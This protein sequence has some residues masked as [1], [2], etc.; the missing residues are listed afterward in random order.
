M[1][2]REAE[3]FFR[4]PY[5]TTVSFVLCA[6]LF[7]LP[8]VD[9]RCNDVKLAQNT[10]FGLAVG[11][12]FR[13]GDDL[14]RLQNLYGERSETSGG[15]SRSSG[16]LYFTALVAFLLAIAGIA[17]SLV[18]KKNNLACIIIGI[19]GTLALVGLIIQLNLDIRKKEN[20]EYSSAFTGTS[21]K[22]NFTVAFYFCMVAFLAAAFLAFKRGELEPVGGMPPPKAPQV[23]IENHGDQSEFP[24]SASESD[25]G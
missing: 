11:K 18:L 2:F 9:I 21:I 25:I 14:K 3:N 7:F 17:V 24:K 6:L 23:P 5:T 15:V 16:K 1:A 13:V 10:G 4:S 20:G 19:A 22:A 8:F 12:D